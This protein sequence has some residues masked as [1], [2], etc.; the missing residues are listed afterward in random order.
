V[1]RVPLR[2]VPYHELGD[3]PN[4]IV[5]GKGNDHTVLTLSH[6]PKSGTPESL[7]ADSSTQIV[8]RYLDRP[9]LRIDV[10]AVSN[11]HFD[12]DGALGLFALLHPDRAPR[13]L[14]LDASIAG[15]FQVH[16]SRQGTRLAWILAVWA[17]PKLSPLG[18]AFFDRPYAEVCAD[19]Y[20]EALERL[21]D[22]IERPHTYRRYWEPEERA[23]ERS[24]VDIREGRVTIEE[25]PSL[26]LSIVEGPA[27]HPVALYSSIRGFRV[28]LRH[29]LR[30]RYESWVQYMTVR[31]IPRVDLQPLADRLNAIEGA[32][33]WS[34]DGVDHTTPALRC[35]RQSRIDMAEFRRL[36][37]DRLAHAPPA[38][39]PYGR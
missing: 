34:F 18:V 5:D 8:Y 11:N 37:E 32:A 31:P 33:V 26:D 29:E 20:R 4:I 38:W 36:T 2:F 12:E 25:V 30:Y 7:Q 27:A 28:M 13:D 3:R 21:P 15:D 22:M 1:P 14:L 6:W 19:L 23:F 10:E 35:C 24:M 39:D 16:R 9:D 17:D